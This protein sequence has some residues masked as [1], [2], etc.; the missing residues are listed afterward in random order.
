[1][2]PACVVLVFPQVSCAVI[3][4]WTAKAVPL[5]MFPWLVVL[6]ADVVKTILVVVAAVRVSPG[7]VVEAVLTPKG[8]I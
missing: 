5:I 1:M 6:D 4:G 8:L 3:T 7:I 2:V